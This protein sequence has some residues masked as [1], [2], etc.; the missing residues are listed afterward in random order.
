MFEKTG[1]TAIQTFNATVSYPYTEGNFENILINMLKLD[2]TNPD[3][4]ENVLKDCLGYL[5]ELKKKKELFTF[6]ALCVYAEKN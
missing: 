4:Y 6:D 5:D 3:K 2:K 1:F